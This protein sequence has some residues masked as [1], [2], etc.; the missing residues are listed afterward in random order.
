MVERSG[1]SGSFGVGFS[2]TR[3]QYWIGFA[4]AV[5]LVVVVSFVAYRDALPAWVAPGN[6]DKVLHCCMAGILAFFLD[7]A[8]GKRSVWKI[9]LA[10]VIILVPIAIEEYLQRL[11]PVRTSSIFDFLADVTGV[12]IAMIAVRFDYGVQQRKPTSAPR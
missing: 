7:G 8:L 5:A 1:A 11:S 4:S 10:A 3:K 9:P 6:M 2:V 12:T